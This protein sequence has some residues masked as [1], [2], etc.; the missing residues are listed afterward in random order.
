MN[1]TYLKYA[2]EIA[3]A[4]SMSKAAERLMIAPPNLTR[5]INELETSLDLRIFE[6]SP[7]GV[8]LTPEGEELIRRSANVLYQIN[9][10]QHIHRNYS[11]TEKRFAASVPRASYICEAFRELTLST[12]DLPYE[13]IYTE[14]NSDQTLE[15]VLD[16]TSDIGIIRSEKTYERLFDEYIKE[17]RL[18]S[19]II[20][21]YR[22]AV[23][24]GTESPLAKLETVTEA[25]LMPLTEIAFCDHAA[26]YIPPNTV[27]KPGM[28]SRIKHHIYVMDVMNAYIVIRSNPDTFVLLPPMTDE[29]I[30]NAGIIQRKCADS[31]DIYKDILVW[32]KGYEFSGTDIEFIDTVYKKAEECGIRKEYGFASQF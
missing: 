15:S 29:T 23:A 3:K 4:G 16:C 12:D 25:D 7:K 14:T 11:R 19:R 1:I 8:T 5:A 30:K 32:R 27:I 6:R 21:E 31:T 20:S 28:T 24:A 22:Y 17:K 26:P 10:I 18:S 9:E 13:F 2:V